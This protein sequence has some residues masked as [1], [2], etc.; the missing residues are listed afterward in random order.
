MKLTREAR[1]QAK[2]LFALTIVDGRVDADRLTK[3]ADGVIA[4]KPRHY[5][6]ILKELSRLVRLEVAKTHAVVESAA[7]LAASEASAIE[8]SLHDRFGRISTEFRTNP[9]LL[10]GVRVRIGSD[11]WDGSVRSRLESLK[12]Q[13]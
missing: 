5:V 3:V 13:I 9:A 8:T 11:V 10:G 2:E 12:S 4:S 1:R 7:A 6:G